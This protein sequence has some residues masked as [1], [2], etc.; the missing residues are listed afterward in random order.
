MKHK[1]RII[2]ILLAI[3]TSFTV[4]YF[5]SISHNKTHDIFIEQTKINVLRLKE[6]FLKDTVNNVIFEIDSLRKKQV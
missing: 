5:Y 3:T 6:D 1:L 2:S 4:M